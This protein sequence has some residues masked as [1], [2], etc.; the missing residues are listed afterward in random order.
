MDFTKLQGVGRASSPLRNPGKQLD[1]ILAWA[2][3]TDLAPRIQPSL[4]A[5]A[6]VRAAAPSRQPASPQDLALDLARRCVDAATA[7]ETFALAEE[8]G[9]IVAESDAE[10]LAAVAGRVAL[11]MAQAHV[12]QTVLGLASQMYD[13]LTETA[14]DAQE[15]Y[16]KATAAT[17]GVMPAEIEA[18]RAGGQIAKNWKAASEALA[19]YAEAVTIHRSI[20]LLSSGG[21]DDTIYNTEA[22]LLEDPREAESYVKAHPGSSLMEAATVLDLTLVLDSAEAQRERVRAILADRRAAHPGSLGALAGAGV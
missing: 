19:S 13:V 22:F 1:A 16:A 5:L 20:R 14:Q 11:D 6:R 10:H 21:A 12:R 18:L 2:S 4:D 15:A 8:A 9:V 17:A 3:G 7:G